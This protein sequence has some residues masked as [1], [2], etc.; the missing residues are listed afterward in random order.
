MDWNKWLPIILL[1]AV[2]LVCCGPMLF[3]MGKG[4]SR[5]RGRNEPEDKPG[6]K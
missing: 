3:M 5:K 2:M 6:Q 4:R 1:I